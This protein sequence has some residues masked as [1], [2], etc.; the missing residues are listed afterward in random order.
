[1]D[2]SQTQIE[3]LI[4]LRNVD[5][6]IALAKRE[7]DALPQR[8]KILEKRDQISQLRQKRSQVQAML[9]ACEDQLT[10]IAQEDDTLATKE[11]VTQAKLDASRADY[12]S[13]EALSRD[14]NGI[15]KRRG[16]LSEELDK[17]EERL[18]RIKP[19]MQQ[20][21]NALAGLESQEA[22]LVDSFKAQGGELQQKIAAAN[23]VRD[24]FVADLGPDLSK[25]Y[26][27]AL[28]RCGGVALSVLTEGSCSAC[29]NT[30][31]AGRL[32]QIKA[33]APLA[34]CPNCHRILLIP[35]A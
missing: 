7:F 1:M 26:D 24:A 32:A 2:A 33:E 3:S 34:T 17:T 19:V 21:D 9:D 10:K 29:R 20:V 11:N 25:A 35:G 30:F 27:E 4:K 28:E 6:E 14:L 16:V 12:R 18:A 13:V 5:R 23:K 31:E 15:A 8:K 22:R